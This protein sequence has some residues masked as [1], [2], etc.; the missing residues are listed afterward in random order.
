MENA[1]LILGIRNSSEKHFK[2]L[3]DAHHA[4]VYSIARRIGLSHE[5]GQDIVQEVFVSLWNQRETLRE[6]LSVHGLLQT[7]TKRMLHKRIRRLLLESDYLAYLRD[8]AHAAANVTSQQ[9]ARNEINQVL[10]AALQL[11]P[12]RRRAV[13]LLSYQQEFPVEEIALALK[14]SVRTAENQLYRARKFLRAYF[15][16]RGFSLEEAALAPGNFLV[17]LVFLQNL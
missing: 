1:E 13:F 4:R 6:D 14:I 5:A 17:L 3:F 10:Q 16:R 7:I 12:E 11:L 8:T 2:A 15:G 9:L